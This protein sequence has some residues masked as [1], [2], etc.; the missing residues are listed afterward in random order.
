[1]QEGDR[2]REPRLPARVVQTHAAGHIDEHRHDGPA[3]DARRHENN[4]TEHEQD[5]RREHQRATDDQ[6]RALR[7]R[8]RCQRPSVRGERD[9]ADRGGQDERDPPGKR[10]GEMHHVRLDTFHVGYHED[11]ETTKATKIAFANKLRV[12]RALR[13]SVKST[14]IE[15]RAI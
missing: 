14:S 10:I 7:S 13:D 5:H 1:L 9:A 8:Q 3:P 15:H 11:T 6:Y 2:T 4:R 12:L